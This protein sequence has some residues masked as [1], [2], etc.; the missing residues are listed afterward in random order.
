MSFE[1]SAKNLG[2]N[3]LL[4]TNPLE[5]TLYPD[6]SILR[7][8][9]IAD[10]EFGNLN[11]GRIAK[12]DGKPAASVMVIQ[13][14]GSNASE[15]IAN[16]KEKIEQIKQDNFPSGMDYKI[17]YDVSRFLDASIQVLFLLKDTKQSFYK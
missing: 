1:I 9:D 6:G 5:T 13:R 3:V 8:K 16:V 10:V 12:M 2:M 7:L 15:V 11:Y 4:D 14:P 17:S